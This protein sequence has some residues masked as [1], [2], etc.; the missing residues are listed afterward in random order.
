MKH[1]DPVGHWEECW[2]APGRKCPREFSEKCFWPPCSQRFLGHFRPGA[3]RH[4]CKWPTRSQVKRLLTHWFTLASATACLG[5]HITK[6]KHLPC[7]IN[8]H[9]FAKDWVHVGHCLRA[10]GNLN[11][12]CQDI[13]ASFTLRWCNL[14]AILYRGLRMSTTTTTDRTYLI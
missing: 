2:R 7:W 10:D 12:L 6:D 8:F 1:W 4:S 9:Y 13:L 14:P 5:L 11:E 3:R